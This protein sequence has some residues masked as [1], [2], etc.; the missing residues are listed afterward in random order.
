[1]VW[2]IFG[3]L[4]IASW[5]IQND[6]LCMWLTRL[7]VVSNFR[8]NSRLIIWYYQTLATKTGTRLLNVCHAFLCKF[9]LYKFL[10]PNRTWL[11]SSARLYFRLALSVS[12]LLLALNVSDISELVW[13]CIKFLMQKTRTSFWYHFLLP[14]SWV[15]VTAIIFLIPALHCRD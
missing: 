7:T 3:I 8:S 14:D 15:F 1:M 9:L 11:V 10:A 4:S 5:L 6:A 2:C 13:T 12:Y